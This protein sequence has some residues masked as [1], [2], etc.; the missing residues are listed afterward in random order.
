MCD[1]D[2]PCT[3]DGCEVLAG[4]THTLRNGTD[5]PECDDGDPCTDPVCT[6]VSGCQQTAK[7]LFAS[8]DCRLADLDALLA[9]N[10]IDTLAREALGG[11]VSVAKTKVDAAETANGEGRTKKVKSGLKSAR[12]KV[13]R[14]GK[15]TVKFEPVH[16]TDPVIAALL[17]DK[18]FDATQRIDALRDEL[19]L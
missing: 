5:V 2:N 17:A 8:V 11:L 13:V 6:I 1:D 15:K 9:G 10:G 18:G 19:G 16:I 3:T 12:K 14:F 7:T 4:C